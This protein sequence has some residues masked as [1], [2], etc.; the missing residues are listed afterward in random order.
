MSYIPVNKTDNH[1]KTSV[2]SNTHSARGSLA[3]SPQTQRTKI[4]EKS[5]KA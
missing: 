4:R 3:F 2:K 1:Q 5:E